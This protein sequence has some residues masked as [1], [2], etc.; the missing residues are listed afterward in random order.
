[1]PPTRSVRPT[2]VTATDHRVPGRNG[3]AH[4]AAGTFFASNFSQ[5]PDGVLDPLGH[6]PLEEAF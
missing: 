6:F 3:P 4:A 1:M 5:P 2:S